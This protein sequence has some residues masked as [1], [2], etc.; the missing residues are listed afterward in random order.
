MQM[1]KNLVFQY[2]PLPL[3]LFLSL[4]LSLT[5]RYFPFSFPLFLSLCNYLSYQPA[6]S[7]LFTK[8]HST[9]YINLS[10]TYMYI[11]FLPIH[12]NECVYIHAKTHTN[13]HTHSRTHA[14]WHRCIHSRTHTHKE[15]FLWYKSFIIILTTFNEKP[16]F[17]EDI[18]HKSYGVQ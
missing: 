4:S 6:F 17:R 11:S 7:A 5:L 12:F 9:K 2:I 3:S 1:E 13:T 16:I 10:K 18:A 15:T 14:Y 8:C